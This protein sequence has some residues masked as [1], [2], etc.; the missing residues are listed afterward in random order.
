LGGHYIPL[1]RSR[2]LSITTTVIL[3]QRAKQASRE[4]AA[5]KARIQFVNMRSIN[6]GALARFTRWI[7][8]RAA[9]G[10]NDGVYISLEVFVGSNTEGHCAECSVRNQHPAQ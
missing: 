3:A 8:A 5:R 6:I 2:F 10:R 4:A 9:L 7:P 1:W